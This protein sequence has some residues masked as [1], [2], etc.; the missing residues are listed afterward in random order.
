MTEDRASKIRAAIALVEDPEVPVTLSDLGVVRDVQIAGDTVTVLMRPTR[1]ACPAR[2]E[3]ARRVE[4]AALA[5]DDSCTVSIEWEIAEWSG[6]DVSPTGQAVL[7]EFGY[8]D[9]GSHTRTCPYCGSAAVRSEGAF[10]GAVCK[11]PFTCRNCG[12]TFDSLRGASVPS[13]E[14]GRDPVRHP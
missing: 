4:D 6:Q 8:A 11:V 3:M 7:V 2:S 5:V 12:S 10:G 1:L 13:H 14:A 9:P